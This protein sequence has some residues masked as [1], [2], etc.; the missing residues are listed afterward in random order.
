MH[1]TD[2]QDIDF[3]VMIYTTAAY[4]CIPCD[5]TCSYV[6]LLITPFMYFTNLY[7]Y[8]FFSIIHFLPMGCLILHWKK[9]FSS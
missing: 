5:V 9:A 4:F 7:L 2:K 8:H 3:L 6:S 1:I